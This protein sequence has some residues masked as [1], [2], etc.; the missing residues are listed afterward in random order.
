MVIWVFPSE[1]LALI[2]S[3]PAIVSNCLISGVATELA[4]V[5]G[6][7]PASCAETLIVGKSACGKAAT[8]S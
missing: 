1:E 8:G 4:I 6:D 7:A 3:I 5:S 2:V